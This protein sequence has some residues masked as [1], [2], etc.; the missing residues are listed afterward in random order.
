RVA[1]VNEAFVQRYLGDEDPLG[2]VMTIWDADWRIVGVCRD[3]RFDHLKAAVPPT[4]YLSFRQ[5][6]YGRLEGAAVPSANF[7]VRSTLASGALRTAVDQALARVD[8]GVP[9]TNVTTQLAQLNR[10][11]GQE[12]MLATLC[13]ALASVA[14]LLCC[15]GLYGLIAYDV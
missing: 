11:I 8:P 14:L 2:H 3:A 13:G 7:A 9:A 15:I 4:T 12:R 1:V 6:F 5:R 10:N